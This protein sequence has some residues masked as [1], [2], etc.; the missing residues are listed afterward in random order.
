MLKSERGSITVFTLTVMLF[1]IVILMGIF[2]STNNA[3]KAQ[4]SADT[5]IIDTYQKDVNIID[6]IYNEK[7]LQIN[8]TKKTQPV[9]VNWDSENIIHNTEEDNAIVSIDISVL[10][11]QVDTENLKCI[12]STSVEPIGTDSELW[13][14]EQATTV[15]SETGKI[16]TTVTYDT[17]FY[18]HILIIKKDN[19]KEEIVSDELK[20]SKSQSTQETE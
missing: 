3:R 2:V 1:F 15:S 20:V 6:E 16:Q 12:V 13:N 5:T 19:S 14:M 18:I 4:K 11:S 7:I 9:K 10:D 8:K 17:S